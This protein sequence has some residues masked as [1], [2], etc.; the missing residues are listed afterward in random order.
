LLLLLV[1]GCKQAQDPSLQEAGEALPALS[2]TDASRSGEK[3]GPIFSPSDLPYPFSAAVQ[4]GDVLYLSGEIG[5]AEDLK[6][7]VPGGIVPETRRM[8]ER[9]E[10]TL[11]AHGLGFEDVFKCTVMLADM[12][13]WP[14]FNEIYAGYFRP[15][16]YPARS[17]MGVNGLALG[18]RVEMEVW[19]YK[20][21]E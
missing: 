21:A 15:G 7:V 11:T 20:M 18:A 19:A 16:S 5:I 14:Q 1:P 4:V 17:A 3:Q 12:A 9:I 13:E 2:E 8:F 6:G 10:A